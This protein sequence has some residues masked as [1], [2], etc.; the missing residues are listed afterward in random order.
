MLYR[1][2]LILQETNWNLVKNGTIAK[3]ENLFPAIRRSFPVDF[4]YRL[5]H[6]SFYRTDPGRQATPWRGEL[7]NPLHQSEYNAWEIRET[8][9]GQE[10]RMRKLPTELS[11]QW[12]QIGGW[13]HNTPMFIDPSSIRASSA[14]IYSRLYA[15]VC[16]CISVC[17]REV[18]DRTLRPI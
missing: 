9:A 14:R 15:P 2:R 1:E 13:L 17:T 10:K 16:T 6:I 5:A 4:T 3:E 12:H 7:H 18:N 11:A 8:D